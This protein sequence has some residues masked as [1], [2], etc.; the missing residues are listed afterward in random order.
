MPN[1]CSAALRVSGGARAKAARRTGGACESCGLDWPWTLY[2]F[3]RDG[4]QRPTAENLL[5]LCGTCSAD[6]TD[7]FAP[8]LSKPTL[9]DRMRER[10]NRRAGAIKL[11]AARRRRLIESRGSACELCGIP[12]SLRDLEV[13]HRVGVLRGGSDDESNLLVLCF[14]CHHRLQPCATGCGR[15]AKKPRRLCGHCDMRR[16]LEERYPELS[17]DE[18]KLRFPG[19]VRAWPVGY[20]PLHHGPAVLP[21][22]GGSKLK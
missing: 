21:H 4:S 12:G 18:I 22:T 2:V 5:I 10:N 13:H 3:L 1:M 19:L 11:T 16:R 17:W 7:A 20:E 6:R 14:A 8:L 15:W 9:R